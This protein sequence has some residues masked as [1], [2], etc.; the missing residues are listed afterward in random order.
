MLLA[1]AVEYFFQ[2]KRSR[3]A[4]GTD[5]QRLLVRWRLAAI[6]WAAA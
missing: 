4:P 6:A 3:P 1:V 5:E 2:G